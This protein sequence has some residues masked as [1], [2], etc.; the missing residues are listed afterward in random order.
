[1]RSVLAGVI[2]VLGVVVAAR[3]EAQRQL[4]FYASL[5]DDQGNPPASLDP[6]AIRVVEN[7]VEGTV[8]KIE[9]ITWPVRVEVLIDNGIG[10]SDALAHIRTGVRGL[11]E[12]LPQGVEVTLFTTAPQPRPVVRRTADR[13]ALLQ[14]VDRIAPDAGSPRFIEGLVEASGRIDRERSY[15]PVFI[16]VGSTAVEGS[17]IRE[18]D[19]ERMLKQF[20][21]RAA[22][23]H[24]VMLSNQARQEGTVTGANQTQVG[25][26]VA[27]YTGGR[28]EAIAATSRLA[29]LLPELGQQVARSH[30]RQSRQFRITFD[31][32][33]GNS[34]PLG[35]VAM[36][37]PAGYRLTLTA[38]GR[39]P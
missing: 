13:F 3:V 16:I 4:V 8:L 19:I 34:G 17:A 5:V 31:R 29:T 38:D 24:V 25:I 22:T 23:V 28:Y 26:A 1:M 10:M 7:G 35:E 11:L 21:E 37:P 30:A 33:D 36:A 6:E 2:V 9:P 39:M 20:V 32:P 18:R 27:K 12:A 15:F 14:G